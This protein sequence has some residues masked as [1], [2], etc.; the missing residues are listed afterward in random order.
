MAK[1]EVLKKATIGGQLLSPSDYLAA[2]EFKGKDVTLTIKSVKVED[3]QTAEGKKRA[4][5]VSF[6]ETKKLLVLTAKVNQSTIAKLHGAAVEGWVDKRITLY[7]TTCNA[8]GNPDTDCIRV[9]PVVPPAK[10]AG[11]QEA[12]APQSE[13]APESRDAQE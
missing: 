5:V 11:S 3:L 4:P 7:P 13:P 6:H 8:F 1:K 10:R 2:V 9:R 12:P